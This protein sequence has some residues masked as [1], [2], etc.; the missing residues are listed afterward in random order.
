MATHVLSEVATLL[1]Y[2]QFLVFVECLGIVVV[3][4]Y[5][6]TGKVGP[7]RHCKHQGVN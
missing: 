4:G 3:C 7:V 1:V 6:M 5:E 2:E